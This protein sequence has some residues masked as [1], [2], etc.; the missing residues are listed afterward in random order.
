M[1]MIHYTVASE[2]PGLIS[3]IQDVFI[4]AGGTHELLQPRPS[5][6]HPSPCISHPKIDW[7]YWKIRIITEGL[8]DKVQL[9]YE[10][11]SK[12]ARIQP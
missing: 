8:V 10:E 6:Q 5:G 3:A 2:Q 7:N 9:N 12:Q 11:S 4:A 1:Y